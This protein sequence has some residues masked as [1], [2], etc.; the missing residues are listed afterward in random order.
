MCKLS[1][2][3]P[4]IYRKCIADFLQ[5]WLFI[6][7]KLAQLHIV[8]QLKEPKLQLFFEMDFCFVSYRDQTKMC[9]IIILSSHALLEK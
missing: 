7:Q 6:E 3:V 4:M 9:K 8:K 5:K 2:L 1:F